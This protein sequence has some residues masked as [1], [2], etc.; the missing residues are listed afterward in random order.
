MAVRKTLTVSL[1]PELQEFVTSR[2]E[3]GM[4][5]SASEVV[6]EGLRLLAEQEVRRKTELAQLRKD[7]QIGVDQARSGD[8]VDGEE[9]FSELARRLAAPSAD[10]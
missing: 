8:L 9:Y 5:V 4:F 7:I 3:T 6:R 10:G 1:T 2:V